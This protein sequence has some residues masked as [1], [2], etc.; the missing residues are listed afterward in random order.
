LLVH[1][2]WGVCV[3]MCIHTHMYTTAYIYAYKSIVG[4][5]FP[6]GGGFFIYVFRSQELGA[7]DPNEAPGNKYE[8]NVVSGA[9]LE[10]VPPGS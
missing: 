6:P 3:Y 4:N 5:L 7:I 8:L 9:P 2:V 10:S 1:M